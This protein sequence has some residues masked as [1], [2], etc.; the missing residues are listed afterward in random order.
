M[1]LTIFKQK[2]K[3]GSVLL[4]VDELTPNPMQP[5]LNFCDD[6]IKTLADSIK[7]Y[8]IIQPL[9]V[10]AAEPF[11]CPLPKPKAL[12]EI[13]CGERRWRAAKLAGLDKVPCVLLDTDRNG[14]AEMALIENI[15]RSDLTFF[16]E[17]VAM[18]NLLLL[19]GKS[20][21]ELAKA[22]SVSQSAL[23]NKLRLLKLNERERTMISE[24]GL[25]ER[26]ARALVRIDNERE[27]RP[28]MLEMITKKLTAPEAEK[29]VDEALS[30]GR[31]TNRK[32]GRDPDKHKKPTIKGSIKDIKIFY[33]TVDRAVKLLNAAGI[34][35]DWATSEENGQ[36][37]VH[38]TLKV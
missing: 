25:S 13:I 22:L 18:Q 30:N 28:L 7:Q 10:R 17:A 34:K 8:G 2:K 14:S 4:P 24:N 31:R 3:D 38:I 1:E 16:E 26:H 12:Y 5:R 19:T 9:T 23:C 6:E 36:T 37:D 11:P 21:T 15:Q 29:L 32:P 33:N 27:R 20:Q 35:A